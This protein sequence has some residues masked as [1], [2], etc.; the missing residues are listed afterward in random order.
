MRALAVAAVF[1][2]LS[3]AAAAS[4][5]LTVL[6]EWFVNPD[7]A[8]LIVA[9]EI[10]AFAQEGLS[11]TFLPQSDASMAPKLVAA[12]HGDIALTEQPQ[13]YQ[14]IDQKLPLR[15]IASL[16]D[17]P[18]ATLTVLADSG[19]R[20]IADL[21]GRRIGYSAG[22]IE[23][24]ELSAI[25]RTAGLN[26]QDVTLIN[27]RQQLSGSL[28]AHQVDAVAVYR[29]FEFLQL[30]D[31]G[32]VPIGFNFEDYG[33]PAYDEI[34]LVTRPEL[35]HDPRIGHFLA[36]LQKGASYLKAHPEESWTLFLRHHT[37]LDNTLNHQSW[38]AT[39]PCFASD[40]A[41]LDRAKYQ[42]YATFLA[43][44]KLIS[45]APAL[46]DYTADI[47]AP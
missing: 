39:L 32:A 17:R 25:L 12:G 37:D 23:I 18:L 24:A 4:E 21:K 2:L 19:I 14:Q 6:L 3:R 41:A 38:L 36:A 16:I 9:Q 40:P 47:P 27:I 11:V 8:P 22:D 43:D 7:H 28:L 5:H 45:A 30:R 15:R 26:L 29:N 44:N 46:A 42:R 20:R 1:M 31:E 33:V 35:T 10:G 13:F 34:I